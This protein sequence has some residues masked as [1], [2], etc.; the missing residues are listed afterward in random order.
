MQKPEERP[1][2]KNDLLESEALDLNDSTDPHTAH[3][4]RTSY[5]PD[6][7]GLPESSTTSLALLPLGL[8]RYAFHSMCS[9]KPRKVPLN[10]LHPFGNQPDQLWIGAINGRQYLRLLEDSPSISREIRTKSEVSLYNRMGTKG[11][12]TS[13]FT[14]SA[15]PQKYMPLVFCGT[16]GVRQ[17]ECS[18]EGSSTT[19]SAVH[20][21][22]SMS[23]RPDVLRRKHYPRN[24]RCMAVTL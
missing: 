22:S 16:S 15:W 23:T 1:S 7:C 3:P 19:H 12:I 17:S 10:T 18:F 24:A 4:S 8:L 2:R 11:K 20:N 6:C 5:T 21:A 13:D 14:S 9:S